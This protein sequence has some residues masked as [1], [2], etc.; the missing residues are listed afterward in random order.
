MIVAALVATLFT[1]A[2]GVRVNYCN[3]CTE[4]LFRGRSVGNVIEVTMDDVGKIVAS[5]IDENALTE[6]L[7]ETVPDLDHLDKIFFTPTLDTPMFM[8][9]V[10]KSIHSIVDNAVNPT[11]T[12]RSP[13]IDDGTCQDPTTHKDV[14]SAISKHVL[15]I[16]T[17][18][19]QDRN[20]LVVERKEMRLKQVVQSL[21][22][23]MWPI[24]SKKITDSLDT[25]NVSATEYRQMVTELLPELSA[26]TNFSG[27]QEVLLF[28]VIADE[29]ALI[30]RYNNDTGSVQDLTDSLLNKLVP[31]LREGIMKDLKK[32]ETPDLEEDMMQEIDDILGAVLEIATKDGLVVAGKLQNALNQES[33]DQSLTKNYIEEV[34]PLL[35][36]TVQ[37]AMTYLHNKGLSHK[38]RINEGLL[39][40]YIKRKAPSEFSN[41]FKVGE[42]SRRFQTLIGSVKPLPPTSAMNKFRRDLVIPKVTEIILKSVEEFRRN[43]PQLSKCGESIL[44]ASV[45]GSIKGR[46]KSVANEYLTTMNDKADEEAVVKHVKE[47]LKK[48]IQEVIEEEAEESGDFESGKFKES[49]TYEEVKLQVES[50]IHSI[51]MK[52][53]KKSEK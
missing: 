8:E 45:V 27:V 43:N 24:A 40:R 5:Q 46:V 19:F 28:P 26:S 17:R 25:R 47:T 35:T 36:S 1:C 44:A 31:F 23:D 10:E 42:F 4:N 9:R 12:V 11:E 49:D 48:S 41:S 38:G 32:I 16:L 21:I 53:M 37:K 22:N 20:S 30:I 34:T 2:S 39:L 33:M 29:L 51:V 50:S 13:K 52:V 6:A 18:V 7:K 3:G 15:H 14:T